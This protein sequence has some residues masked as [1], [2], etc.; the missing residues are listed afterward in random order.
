MKY[1]RYLDLDYKNVIDKISPYLLENFSKSNSFFV[2][3]NNQNILQKF[4]EIQKIFDPLNIHVDK[5]ALIVYNSTWHNFIHIDDPEDSTR[6]NFPILNCEKSQT[7]FYQ[8]KQGR[9]MKT[10]PAGI[11]SNVL[12]AESQDCVLVDSFCLD[13]AT[14]LRTNVLHNVTLNPD[15]SFRISLTAK[16]KENIDYFLE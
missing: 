10:D 15:V 12:Y 7:N 4:P 6:I 3:L 8:L 1:Y 2:P 14:V 13:Q 9:S 5:L 16:F 11:L